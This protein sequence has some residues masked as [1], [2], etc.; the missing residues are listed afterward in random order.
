MNRDEYRQ[1]FEGAP[2]IDCAKMKHDIQGRIYEEIKDMSWEQRREYIRKG[3][4]ESRRANEQRMMRCG[5]LA[6]RE[7]PLEYRTKEP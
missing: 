7:D 4:D 1:Q 2:P 3:S 5:E 6:V